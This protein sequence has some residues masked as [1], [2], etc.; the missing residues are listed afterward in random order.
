MNNDSGYEKSDV[1]VGRIVGWALVIIVVLVVILVLMNEFFI[2]SKD[3]LIYETRLKPESKQLRDLRA[4]EDQI[5]NSYKVLDAEAGLYQI[6]VERAMKVMAD[7]AYV[8]RKEA[9]QN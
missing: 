5:L 4:R 8:Q 1:N 2:Y 6:P 3:K 7:E 9:R